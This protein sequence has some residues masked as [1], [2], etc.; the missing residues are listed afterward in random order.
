[1]LTDPRAEAARY[2]DLN[3]HA[4][5][6]I[7]F[8]EARVTSPAAHILELGCGTGRVL[9]PLARSCG[10]IHGI[11]ASE[12]MLDLCRSKL[13]AAGIPPN[14]AKVEVRDITAST[15]VDDSTSLSRPIGSSRTWKPRLRW[16]ACFTAC[17]S[18][19]VLVAPAF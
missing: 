2:Y 10:Y 4:P 5:N 1:M 14:K 11:D 16:M 3:P 15:W 18:T 19:S 6:D 13:L 9:V 12:A 17:G 7:P 8:Y